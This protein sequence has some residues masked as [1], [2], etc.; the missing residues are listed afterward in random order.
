MQYKRN[1]SVVKSQ[2]V[3]KDHQVFTKVPCKIHIPMRFSQINLAEI[4]IET[5][6]YG[7]FAIILESGEYA[8]MNIMAMVK[9]NPDK[10]LTTE[11]NSE[12]YYEFIFDAG[13]TIIE[14]TSVIRKDSL[15]YPVIN[16]LIFRG[17]VPWYVDY[18]DLGKAF[19][20]GKKFADN[21]AGKSYEVNELL[22]SMISRSRKDRAIFYRHS[23]NP[24]EKKPDYIALTSIFYSVKNTVNKLAGNYFT[25][26]LV[27]ALV[28]PSQSTEKIEQLLRA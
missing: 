27:S 11:I 26:G 14:N 23:E 21:N 17:G 7:L 6:I 15:F 3:T 9:I 20:S 4:G 18:E 24:K 5:Y 16:E 25:E 22:A 1:A 19:D 8:V 28:E 2:L 13:S 10:V 12:G